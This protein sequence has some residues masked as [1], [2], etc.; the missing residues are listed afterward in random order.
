MN[1]NSNWLHV[2]QAIPDVLRLAASGNA[3]RSATVF[4]GSGREVGRVRVFCRGMHSEVNKLSTPLNGSLESASAGVEA[5]AKKSCCASF[6]GCSDVVGIANTVNEP[7]VFNPVVISEPTDVINLALMELTKVKGPRQSMRL[8]VALAN[9]YLDVP[10]AGWATGLVSNPGGS[11]A[12]YRPKEKPGIRVVSEHFFCKL[13]VFDGDDSRCRHDSNLRGGEFV[14]PLKVASLKA[15]QAQAFEPSANSCFVDFDA[16]IGSSGAEFAE[17]GG[18]HLGCGGLHGSDLHSRLW[19]LALT[20]FY[21][22]E[23][24]Q[25]GLNGLHAGVV[26]VVVSDFSRER[27]CY[28]CLAGY[29][30]PPGR[31]GLLELAFEVVND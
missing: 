10:S 21:G 12:R 25:Q 29:L 9:L 15:Q 28:S 14:L 27:F 6:A 4:I 31:A 16:V 13:N 7:Q 19:Q 2:Y 22:H 11:T 23:I 3:I 5:D 1:K 20:A 17:L 8:E 18:G 26:A 24:V 30:L